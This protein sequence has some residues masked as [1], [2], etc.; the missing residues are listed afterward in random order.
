MVEVLLFYLS[1]HTLVLVLRQE[2][3]KEQPLL[4]VKEKK[5][6]PARL[7]NTPIYPFMII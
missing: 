1:P 2:A 6:V 5:C 7:E 4:Q 3:Y